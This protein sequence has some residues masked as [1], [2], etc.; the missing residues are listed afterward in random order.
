MCVCVYI[1]VCIYICTYSYASV[2]VYIYTYIY[3]YMYASV[4]IIY[5]YV[6]ILHVGI[7]PECSLSHVLCMLYHCCCLLD[8]GPY[9]SFLRTCIEV[10]G[11]VIQQPESVPKP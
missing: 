5:I 2:C 10:R 9:I 11:H 7:I 1:S 3:T 6:C 8:E 4:Y